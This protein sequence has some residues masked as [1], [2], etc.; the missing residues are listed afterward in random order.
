MNRFLYVFLLVALIL[1][2][3]AGPQTQ[4]ATPTSVP[5]EVPTETPVPT[6]APTPT[7]GDRA[8]DPW[9]WC[10]RDDTAYLASHWL[11]PMGIE[12]SG[13]WR[14]NDAV[15]GCA[16]IGH[17]KL[18]NGEAYNYVVFR[19]EKGAWHESDPFPAIFRWDGFTVPVYGDYIWPNVRYFV[20][21][22]RRQAMTVISYDGTNSPHFDV[23]ALP[24]DQITPYTG[25]GNCGWPDEVQMAVKIA[26]LVSGTAEAEYDGW[27]GFGLPTCNERNTGIWTAFVKDAGKEYTLTYFVTELANKEQLWG[28]VKT[29]GDAFLYP[30][31]VVTSTT[32]V[33]V[34]AYQMDGLVKTFQLQGTSVKLVKTQKI[35]NFKVFDQ[36]LGYE[37]SVQP[38]QPG[39]F[40]PLADLLAKDSLTDF[41]VDGDGWKSL[42][43]DL[44]YLVVF[45]AEGDVWSQAVVFDYRGKITKPVFITGDWL[46]Y[47]WQH[48]TDNVVTSCFMG[49]TDATGTI[50]T[51]TINGT[52]AHL[53]QKTDTCTP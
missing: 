38:G 8:I 10:Q 3:C 42:D 45:Y 2:A 30:L 36:V 7:P 31:D 32:N 33:T 41:S 19:D 50:N 37:L 47:H 1:S 40:E 20:Y 22:T 5:T 44:K 24:V 26:P 34:R 21:D 46:H 28:P 18:K 53:S 17:V 27:R 12:I 48:V 6:E 23:K 39:Y 51:F 43:D 13:V 29:D 25:S 14:I 11:Y 15:P 4:A 52:T 35:N 49:A 9:T 16:Y